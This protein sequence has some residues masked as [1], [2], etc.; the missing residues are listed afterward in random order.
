LAGPINEAVLKT[1]SQNVV[2]LKPPWSQLT[3]TEE[4]VAMTKTSATVKPPPLL[5][6]GVQYADQVDNALRLV[7]IVLLQLAFFVLQNYVSSFSI[8]WTYLVAG[9]NGMYIG[10][11]CSGVSHEACHRL[12]FRNKF[13][14]DLA[15]GLT[16]AWL[17]IPHWGFT[18]FHHTHHQFTHVESKEPK[19]VWSHYPF[20][21]AAT[22][23][24]QL[25]PAT[26]Y[27]YFIQNSIQNPTRFLADF[28]S[29]Y[30]AYYYYVHLLPA[31]GL[32]VQTCALPFTLLQIP[33]NILRALT[34]HYGQ[35]D[36]RQN[37]FEGPGRIILYHEHEYPWLVLEW[38]G[39]HGNYHAVHHKWP[40]LPHAHYK[41]VLQQNKHLNWAMHPGY[42]G[43][44]WQVRYDKGSYG[45]HA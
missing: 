1:L 29:L 32:P 17:L 4:A 42:I 26:W 35:P 36:A 27:A 10:L 39:C 37:K 33:I 2:T 24:A 21:F 20:W 18:Q 6:S 38:L 15:G 43:I 12:Y 13:L 8:Q 23:G 3:D 40:T 30:S 28:L 31:V 7:A 34:D 11:G 14:N 5:P 44:L 25:A 22:I 45:K 19:D 16:H 41:Q 9:L